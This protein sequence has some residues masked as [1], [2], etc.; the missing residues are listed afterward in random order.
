M[1]D[2]THQE[3]PEDLPEQ[4]RG[5]KGGLFALVLA[6]VVV[7]MFVFAYANAEFFVMICQR[8]GL[9]S[10]DPQD[11]RGVV[12]GEGEPGRKLEVYFTA[13]VNDNLPMVMSVDNKYQKTNV[14]VSTINDYR[15][16]NLSDKVIYFKPVHDVY[17]NR[18]GAPEV[19]L[20][21]KCF[22]FDLQKIDPNQKY[23]LPVEYTF[24]E[25]L[26]PKV[27]IIRMSYTVF[28]SSKEAYD[29]FMAAEEEEHKDED[30][31]K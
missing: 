4:Q 20:L 12:V 29:A 7:G 1:K 26:D 18:A 10:T 21:T 2:V 9:L 16:T 27:G 6:L 28:P 25:D 3:F 5:G 13:Q 17:P 14:N 23:S 11:L 19:M 22:C 15:F 24:T 30:V 8:A 31:A